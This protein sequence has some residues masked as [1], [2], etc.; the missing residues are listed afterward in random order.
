MAYIAKLSKLQGH[1]E[2][3]AL[4]VTFIFHRVFSGFR[5]VRRSI[6]RVRG[7]M[8]FKEEWGRFCDTQ[9]NGSSK[10]MYFACVA[11]LPVP[12]C[13]TCRKSR[14]FPEVNVFLKNVQSLLRE[15]VKRI[16]EVKRRE[17]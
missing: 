2:L 5:A 16:G 3:F 17:Y 11:F 4:A 12:R 15:L 1:G 8:G 9:C 14:Y 7:D 6:I 10:A 13:L